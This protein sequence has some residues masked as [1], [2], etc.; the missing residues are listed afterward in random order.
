MQGGI[1]MFGK[2]TVRIAG[3]L[4][5]AA[6]FLLP[7]S[8]QAQLD[9][10]VRGGFYND[11]DAGFLGAEVLTGLTRQW[12]FNP[13]VEYVFVDIGSLTTLNLDFHYD[14]PA[15]SPYSLWVGGGPAVLFN[16]FDEGRCT[17]CRGDSGTQLGLDLLAGL[18]FWRNQ[19]IRPYV[20]GK[21]VLSN[22]TEAVLGVGIRFD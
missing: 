9:F 12:F 8:A 6:L 14:L 19:A 7:G 13:N 2:T 20:Q 15:S 11:A 4:A 17:R 16:S 18:G 3:A 22:N 10:G 21:V 1:E 5:V